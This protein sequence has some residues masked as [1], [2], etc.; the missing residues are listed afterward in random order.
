MPWRSSS[1]ILVTSSASQN[2]ARLALVTV[3]DERC[4]EG[5]FN[6]FGLKSI[7]DSQK[8]ACGAGGQIHGQSE[9]LVAGERDA[10]AVRDRVPIEMTEVT[11]NVLFAFGK[12]GEVGDHP[13]T[14]PEEPRFDEEVAA[15]GE[16]YLRCRRCE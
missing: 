1:A 13:R 2:F 5:K 15:R 9:Q 3:D 12:R 8:N 10:A 14:A 16:L 7:R 11:S 4:E 6:V